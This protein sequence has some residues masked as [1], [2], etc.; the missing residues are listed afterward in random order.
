MSN[1][2]T[3]IES[4]RDGV[5]EYIEH[6]RMNAHTMRITI[7]TDPYPHQGYGVVDRWDGTQWHPVVRI[8]GPTLVLDRSRG[9]RERTFMLDPG[10]FTRD[11]DRLL[12][13][14]KEVLA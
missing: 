10:D 2:S 4:V 8:A 1:G 9:H 7:H 12:T 5:L 11:R 6:L 13:L 3:R 14:A